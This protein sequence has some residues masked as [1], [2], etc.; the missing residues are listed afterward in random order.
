MDKTIAIENQT[1]VV[2]AT[3]SPPEITV[4]AVVLSF[5]LTLLLGA[6]NA[7]LGLKV[8]LTV[9]AS[10]PAAV[11]S[12]GILRFFKNSNILENNIVQTAASA[13]EALTAGV[14]FTL[15]ALIILGATTEFHYWTTVMVA[16]VGGIL[17]VLF[18]IP[19]RRL[20]I[21][22]KNLHFPEGTA[23][24]NVLKATAN[25]AAGLHHLLWGALASALINL[26]Q[27]GFKIVSSGFSV[28]YSF[29][30]TVLGFGLGYSPALIGAGYII[31][32]E[33]GIS[34][35][36]G[37]VIGWMVG[38]PL[39]GY[40][41]G[42]PADGSIGG[43]AHQ[44][45][46][47]HIRFIGVGT[48]LTGG[49]LSVLS[50]V[51]PLLRGMAKRDKLPEDAQQTVIPRTE[52]DIPFRYVRRFTI[53]LALPIF[54][55]MYYFCHYFVPNE[56]VSFYLLISAVSLLLIVVLGFIISAIVA[57]IVG[58]VGSS[59]SPISGLTIIAL[60]ISALLLSAL[61]PELHG[62]QLLGMVSTTMMIAVL[63]ATAAAISND[64]M[65]DLKTGQL[66]GA[67]PWKQQVMLMFGV[68]VAA[69]ILPAVLQLLF[70]A[71]GLGGV[72]PRP[73]M[74]PANMLLAPQATIMATIVQGV[75]GHHVPWLMLGIGVAIAVA[76]SL[77]DSV[78]RKRFGVRFPTLG[79]GLG[80]Y[81]PF[82][83]SMPLVL[84]GVASFITN[85]GL[86]R[87][88]ATESMNDLETRKQNGLLLACGI[89]AGAA[90]MGVFLAIPFV[91]AGSANAL[92][93][94]PAGFAPIAGGIAI[95]IVLGIFVWFHRVVCGR[96]A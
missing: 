24:A 28:W 45:W 53:V 8:G 74:D 76:G 40:F 84:G 95:V 11:I 49:V 32:M 68:I 31:G 42:L 5:I 69:F 39:V 25:K 57:Y 17:G 33:I 59:A 65:Q 92:S 67:T 41:Y 35:V 81:L 19:L 23:I 56:T 3:E 13:G 36:V 34:I 29:S 15:P 4:R 60:I 62:R 94:A 82:V 73:G 10:I 83:A 87:L 52:L 78:L 48:L 66:V 64:T 9:S 79:M 38:L 58:L 12:M 89:V 26:G 44:L 70:D 46:N 16:S 61:V 96:S 88:K 20:M 63:I 77:L 54:A 50:M 1:S 22:D 51:I 90:L 85:R 21:Y 2:S 86:K 72:F 55:M 71:Y 37:V 93:I 47:T 43:I 91:I 27:T 14:A 7:Y 75:F 80:I 6:A 30:G 18:S